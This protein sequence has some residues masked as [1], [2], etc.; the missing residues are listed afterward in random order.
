MQLTWSDMGWDAF[1][2][3]HGSRGANEY[4]KSLEVRAGI[5]LNHQNR[6]QDSAGKSRRSHVYGIANLNY[7]FLDG[8]RAD[9]SGARIA[10]QEERL[11]TGLGLGRSYSWADDRFTLYL[12]GSTNTAIHDFGDRSRLKGSA[13]FR[14][15]VDWKSTRLTSSTQ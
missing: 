10:H 1:T 6:W 3:R 15:R 5:S 9:V 12:E 11:W 14:M 8:T 13:G 2:E 4:G 7:E